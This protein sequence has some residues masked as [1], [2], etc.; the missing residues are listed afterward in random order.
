VGPP[1]R[2]CSDADTRA[3][4]LPQMCSRWERVLLRARVQ[5][6][7]DHWSFDPDAPGPQQQQGQAEGAGVG[8]VGWDDP[9]LDEA[10]LQVRP[11]APLLLSQRRALLALTWQRCCCV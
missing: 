11:A 8:E 10:E 3:H 1:A 6:S 7:A 5:A 2:L 9:P 4:R